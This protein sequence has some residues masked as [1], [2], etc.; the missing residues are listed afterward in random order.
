MQPV[1]LIHL[2]ILIT[3]LASLV[4]TCIFGRTAVYTMRYLNAWKMRQYI[5]I[6]LVLA[7]FSS[8]TAYLP[9]KS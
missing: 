5:L 8:P 4:A 3:I 1:L 7:I 9:A 6:R 2:P